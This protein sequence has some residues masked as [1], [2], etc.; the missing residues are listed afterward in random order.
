MRFSIFFLISSALLV[1]AC[2][3][4]A[5]TGL[6]ATEPLCAWSGSSSRPGLD[7]SRTSGDGC[8]ECSCSAMTGAPSEPS[9]TAA[10][11][12]GGNL[13]CSVHSDCGSGGFCHFDP[14]CSGELGWCTQNN[15]RCGGETNPAAGPNAADVF[16][17]CDGLTYEG[18]QC[19]GKPWRHRGP[20]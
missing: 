15:S 19:I 2:G 11:C 20:C 8:N 6:D 10:G 1:A 9:C 18:A 5:T 3:E 4:D 7:S 17:G 13:R 16:C 12:L 14:G